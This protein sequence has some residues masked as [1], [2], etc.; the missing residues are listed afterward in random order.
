MP[1]KGTRYQSP[2]IFQLVKNREEQQVPDPQK[3][4]EERHEGLRFFAEQSTEGA[5]LELVIEWVGVFFRVFWLAVF[6][7]SFLFVWVFILKMAGF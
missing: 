4:P 2:L 5:D 7:G 6:S 1:E 3:N